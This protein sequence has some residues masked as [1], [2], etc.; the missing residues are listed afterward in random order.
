MRYPTSMTYQLIQYET[1]TAAA[2]H[3]PE[4]MN[5]WDAADDRSMTA[6]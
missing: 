4:K 5:A 3:R 6:S 2:L 1:A